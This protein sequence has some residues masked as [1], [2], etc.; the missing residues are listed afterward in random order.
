MQYDLFY[1]QF[2]LSP[3]SYVQKAMR[4]MRI[5]YL[6]SAE[7][8]FLKNMNGKVNT[9]RTKLVFQALGADE[10]EPT[11]NKTYSKLLQDLASIK[12][13]AT[14][15]LV[16]KE[17]IWPVQPDM[18]LGAPTTLVS[19]AHKQGLEVYASTIAMILHLSTF[20]LL[21][22]LSFLLMGCLQIS[23][24]QHQKPLVR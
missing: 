5:N 14:G 3:A 13:F 22:I 6:S 20:S 24:L 11:T 12:S 19:D 17:Y 7:I 23:L 1:N 21:I 16:P 4:S 8:G 10:I 2:K 15:I 18:Y 9:A